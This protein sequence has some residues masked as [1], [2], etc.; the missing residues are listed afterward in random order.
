MGVNRATA[1]IVPLRGTK[2]PPANASTVSAMP[3]YCI[4]F[5]EGSSRPR[6]RPK[7]ANRAEPSHAS[8]GATTHAA[9]SIRA[10]ETAPRAVTTSTGTAAAAS[11]V[12][13]LIQT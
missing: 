6:N 1:S 11:A 7:A 3:R 5:S 4:T 9:P 2:S 12:S 13:T 10:P 8:S